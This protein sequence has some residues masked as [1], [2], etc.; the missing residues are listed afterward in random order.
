MNINY[1]III[2]HY[3]TP[4]LLYRCLD[5]IPNREDIQIIVVDDNSDND[6]R[7]QISKPNL[8]IVYLSK[9]ESKGA[10][11]ARNI[12]LTKAAGEWLI[13]AD[14]DDFY[15]N[16]ALD[17]CDKYLKT[18]YDIIYFGSLKSYSLLA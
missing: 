8:E 6:K 15:L 7:P 16:G 13:F 11:R 9:E 17:L 2:P 14:A 12:G 5:S 18:K 1:T 10:G 4:K 3:N